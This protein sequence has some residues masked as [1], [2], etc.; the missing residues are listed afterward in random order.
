MLHAG[1]PALCR[2]RVRS[3]VGLIPLSP[4][5]PWSRSSD[6]LPV[7]TAHAWFME[8]RPELGDIS[9]LNRRMTGAPPPVLGLRDRLKVSAYML[10]EIEFLRPTESERSRSFHRDH[11]YRLYVER[12][13]APSDYEPAESAPGSSAVI[14]T[15]AVRSGF[16]SIF[17]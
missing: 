17:C 10:D 5:K 1:R 16:R 3:M 12:H 4:W 8:N 2:L 7:Q 11:P 9:K 6:G 14:R 15:G 13:G